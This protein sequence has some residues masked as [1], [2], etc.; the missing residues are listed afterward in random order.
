MLG[1]RYRSFGSK[2]QSVKSLPGTVMVFD[3]DRLTGAHGAPVSSHPDRSPAKNDAF[4]ELPSSMPSVDRVTMQGTVCLSC[5]DGDFLRVPDPGGA[6]QT[7]CVVALV[8]VG[9][10]SPQVAVTQDT[11]AVTDKPSLTVRLA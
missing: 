3:F 4:Q 10:T 2:G 11:T 9:A 8:P 5:G 1:L 6:L 7:I